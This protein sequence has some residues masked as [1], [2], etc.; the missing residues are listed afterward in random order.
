M[1]KDHRITVA[2]GELTDVCEFIVHLTEVS[3]EQTVEEVTARDPS[4][5]E[6]DKAR[7]SPPSGDLFFWHH[8]AMWTIS[9]LREKYNDIWEE[10]T[11]AYANTPTAKRLSDKTSLKETV[12]QVEEILRDS[13]F[14][15]E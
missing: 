6:H 2:L 9:R 1:D 5:I 13:S 11:V 4:F 15:E 3:R 7:E 12:K 8:F 14:Q 10:V